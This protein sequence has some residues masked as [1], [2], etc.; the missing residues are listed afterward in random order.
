[1]FAFMRRRV[2]W[3]VGG[4]AALLLAGGTIGIAWVNPQLTRYLESYAF[5]KELEKETAK[6]LHFPSGH[7]EPI[8]R[9]GTWT[10]ESAGFQ[11]DNGCARDHG[12]VQSLGRV[13]PA[14]ATG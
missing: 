1:M 10:A 4:I 12:Q 3:I 13:S 7:Y 5:R 11:A 14:L 8:K 2:W 9:T 6:G